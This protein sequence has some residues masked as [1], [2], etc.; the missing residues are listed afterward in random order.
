M[1]ARPMYSNPPIHGAR[2]VDIILSDK[3]LTASWHQDLIN[4]S[5][6]MKSM[7][8]GLVEKLKQHGSVHN[9]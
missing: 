5:T 4:M 3:D 7:R 8:S 1:I 2:I 9:W 6:R